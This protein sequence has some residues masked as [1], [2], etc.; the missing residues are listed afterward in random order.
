MPHQFVQMTK[1]SDLVLPCGGYT[2]LTMVKL[3]DRRPGLSILRY[4]FLRLFI[5]VESTCQ[6]KTA[7]SVKSRAYLMCKRQGNDIHGHLIVQ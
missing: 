4:F 1:L 7:V 3:L 2:S 5:L 6:K